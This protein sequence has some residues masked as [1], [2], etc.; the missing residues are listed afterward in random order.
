MVDVDLDVRCGEIVRDWFKAQSKYD[1]AARGRIYSNL[2]CKRCVFILNLGAATMVDGNN[3][4]LSTL[5]VW[6]IRWWSSDAQRAALVGE[7]TSHDIVLIPQLCC[8]QKTE[9]YQEIYNGPDTAY[10]KAWDG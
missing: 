2:K 4:E 10:T 9:V 5:H 7:G 8:L 1:V 6:T 3:E